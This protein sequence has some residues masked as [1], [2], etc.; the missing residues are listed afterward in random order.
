MTITVHNGLDLP[1]VGGSESVRWADSAG[2]LDSCVTNIV[3]R[4]QVSLTDMPLNVQ[5]VIFII[6]DIVS[7]GFAFEPAR[8]YKPD[9]N[10]ESNSTSITVFAEF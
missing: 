7:Q 2:D 4:C 6:D 8:K 10:G 9:V 5:S 3:G 1:V